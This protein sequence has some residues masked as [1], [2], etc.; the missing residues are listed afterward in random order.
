[1]GLSAL[2]SAIIVICIL[3][4]WSAAAFDKHANTHDS[5]AIV[6]D[7][8]AGLWITFLFIAPNALQIT[9]AFFLFRFFDVLKPFPISWCDKNIKGASGVMIDD[10]LAGLAAG[11]LIWGVN[12]AGLI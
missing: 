1:M 10:I 5:G 4:W 9:L 3:G 7:E 12:Y 2:I 6:I 11:L 8:V